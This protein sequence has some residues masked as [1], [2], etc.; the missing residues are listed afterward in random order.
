MVVDITS[1]RLG[2]EDGMQEATSGEDSGHDSRDAKA[3]PHPALAMTIAQHIQF[4]ECS[5][6]QRSHT[7]ERYLEDM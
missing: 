7:L 2:T 3:R 4:T 5:M 6:L 1:F